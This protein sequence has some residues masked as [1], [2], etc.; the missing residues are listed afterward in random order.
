MSCIDMTSINLF[1]PNFKPATT[2]LAVF[3]HS[4]AVYTVQLEVRKCTQFRK[5][6]KNVLGKCRTER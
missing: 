5:T 6:P 2:T 4:S 3:V 1:I